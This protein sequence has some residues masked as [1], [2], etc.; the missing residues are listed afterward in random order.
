MG[1]SSA[2]LFRDGF[3]IAAVEEER[4][5][6]IKNDNNFPH[7]SI[8]EVLDIEGIQL[9]NINNIAV[10]WQPWR[11]FTRGY[12]TLKKLLNSPDSLKSVSLKVKKLF[13]PSE[14]T[15]DGSWFDLFRIKKILE[16][17]HGKFNGKIYFFNHH[18]TH[19]KYGEIITND[20][21]FISLSYDGGGESD[22]TVLSVVL[23]GKRIILKKHKWPN[24]LGH[25]YSFFTGFLGFKMLE[26][27]Y[28]MMGLAPY[29]KPIYR[30][31]ILSNILKLKGNGSYQLNTNLCD[32]HSAL[33]GV[34]SKDFI[35]LFGEKRSANEDLS[36]MHID[37]ACSVQ[38]SFEEALNHVL[39]PAFI[40]FPN[41]KKI[42]ITGGC[43]LN[44]SANGKLLSNN[45]VKK[46]TIPPAPHDAGCSIGA[47]L[48]SIKGKINHKSVRNPY[49]GRIF[50]NNQISNE[51]LKYFECIEKFDNNNLIENTVNYLIEGNLVAWFQ[52]GSEFGPRALGARS[53]LADPRNDK[54]RDEINKKIKKREL[55]RPFAPSTTSDSYQD[56]FEMNQNSPYMNIV[57]NVRNS[58]IPAI[59]H[60]DG[61]A[62]VHTVTREDN[63]RYYDLISLFG[64]KTG[65]PVI[66]NTSFNIQE[67]I[68][69]S[70]KDAIVTFIKSEVDYLVIG[71]YIASREGLKKNVS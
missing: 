68:V 26:G 42:V 54:I 13:T 44:V 17:S 22:S 2:A 64:K 21:S 40:K 48:C 65:I 66:L 61:T 39:T 19:Q 18:L 15:Q 10:Y 29:G 34:F 49:L 27:E 46:V 14:K 20:K 30:K 43:A 35:Q 56:F 63:Q 51:L 53:F 8:K 33:R 69:Y 11:I 60:I 32:Y 41:I 5:S 31:K 67:P 71:N 52:G 38:A 3:L 50:S 24:S 37:L 59:T 7:N 47:A 55:F 45:L 4:L 23:D 58:N 6:R 36:Q 25:F 12:G 70:P 62:R 9:Q 57:S 16:K 28:K 1:T